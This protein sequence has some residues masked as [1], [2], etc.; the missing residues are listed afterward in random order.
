M[1]RTLVQVPTPVR[2]GEI[3]EITAMAAHPMETGYR[4]GD[5]GRPVP[6]HIVQE[7]RCELDGQEI[8]RMALSAAITANPW[9]AFPLRAQRSGTLRFTWTDDRAQT[10]ETRVWLEVRE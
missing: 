5:D 2:R 6:R 3:I 4:T 9:V 7:L 8:F 1:S 10:V